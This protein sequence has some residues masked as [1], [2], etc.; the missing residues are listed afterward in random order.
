MSIKPLIKWT[1]GK[2]SEIKYIE[3]FIPKEYDRYIE[4][5]VGGG[6]LY[7]YLCPEH[8][9]INDTCTDLIEFYKCM[10]N[11]DQE[12]YN[13]LLE[14]SHS[15]Q[16]LLKLCEIDI[17]KLYT[18]YNSYLESKFLNAGTIL[19]T[20]SNWL[21]YFSN[22]NIILDKEKFTLSLY[23][24]GCEGIKR[25]ANVMGNKDV[26]EAETKENIITKFMNGY[27]MYFR[28]IYNNIHQDN[29]FVSKAYRLANFY[30]VRQYCYGGMFRYNKNGGFNVPYGGTSYNRID[31]YSKV[32]KMFNDTKLKTLLKNTGMYNM[33][34]EE[35]FNHINL[36]E[37]DFMFLDPPYDTT[38]STY[39]K[40]DFTQDDHI[41]LANVLKQYPCKFLLIINDNDFTRNLYKDFIIT[42]FDKKYSVNFRNRNDNRTTH[43]I[44]T[45]YNIEQENDDE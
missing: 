38:F 39:D 35:L 21:P 1:G 19:S 28:D 7:F 29:M 13:L 6:A 27:Y 41:R 42:S 44:I 17:D 4:P 40:T 14:Y 22:Y 16:I 2:R 18:V 45:N 9:I 11:S 3:P 20:V 25:L 12:L 23:K 36:S 31:L 30:F 32:T 24:Y 34:F 43:L 15:I 33:D 5:F 37:N 10:Q 8:S 26:S